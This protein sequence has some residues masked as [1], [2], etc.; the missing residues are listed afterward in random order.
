MNVG[1][2]VLDA[3]KTQD[4]AEAD[5]VT[6]LPHAFYPESSWRDDLAWGAAE[7]ALAGQALGDPRADAW[8][9]SGAHWATEYLASEAGDDTLNLYDTSALAMA[10][11]VRAMR[12]ARHARA[13]RS[14]RRC[15]SRAWRPS[16]TGPSRARRRTR[17]GRVSTTTTS[18]P[19]RT[20]S[21]WS[22]PRGCTGQL[23]GDDRYEAFAAAATWTGCS[24]PTRGAPR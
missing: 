17:S 5:V 16:S 8:L 18:M 2:Q 1:A 13:G 14:A 4:V 24:A 10:D 21:A 11:L 23:T 3:A 7:L 6:A 22:R 15:C 9:A 20:P 12:A 19:C